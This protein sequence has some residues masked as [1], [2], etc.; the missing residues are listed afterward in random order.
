MSPRTLETKAACDCG[1]SGTDVPTET[2]PV[3]TDTTAGAPKEKKICLNCGRPVT[4]SPNDDDQHIED[5]VS[6]ARSARSDASSPVRTGTLSRQA[7][8]QRL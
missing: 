3:E 5:P 8:T 1:G 2:V 4:R 7:R 6:Q